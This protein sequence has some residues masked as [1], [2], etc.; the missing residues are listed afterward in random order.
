MHI[1]QLR[2][3]RILITILRDEVRDDLVKIDRAAELRGSLVGF[4]GDI[5]PASLRISA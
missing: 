1:R 5:E 2:V 3:K 4:F